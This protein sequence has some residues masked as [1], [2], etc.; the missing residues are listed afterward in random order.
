MLLKQDIR[1]VTL[2]TFTEFYNE[3]HAYKAYV[4]ELVEDGK[5]SALPE[6]VYVALLNVTRKEEPWGREDAEKTGC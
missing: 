1:K 5:L 6:V 4:L 3:R 2:E